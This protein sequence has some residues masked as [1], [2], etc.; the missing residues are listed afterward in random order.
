MTDRTPISKRPPCPLRTVQEIVWRR[1]GRQDPARG[2]STGQEK[3]RIAR[4]KNPMTRV[5]GGLSQL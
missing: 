3:V 4:I 2:K 1:Q 5:D